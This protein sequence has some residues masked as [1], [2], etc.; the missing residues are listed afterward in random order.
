MP[1]QKKTSWKLVCKEISIYSLN[2]E[3]KGV[4]TWKTNN[5]GSPDTCNLDPLINYGLKDMIGY[6]WPKKKTSWKLICKE[7]SFCS[8][9]LELQSVPEKKY[10]G[11]PLHLQPW[12]TNELWFERR[13]RTCL[14]KK[15]FMKINTQ[16]NFFLFI[17][18]RIT[19]CTWKKVSGASLTPLTLTH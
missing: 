2:L 19:M 14:T 6:A 18:L 1:D 15:Y 3:L 13:G 16:R 5:W 7:I 10:L 8:L 17:K 9:N 11:L 12:S 4:P